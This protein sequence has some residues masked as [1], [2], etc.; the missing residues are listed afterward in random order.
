MADQKVNIKVSTTGA[1]KSK[2]ELSGLNGAI[3]KMGKAVGVASAAYF[4]AKGL[5]SAFSTVIEASARQEQ[6][7][8]ALEVALG[9]TSTALLNQASALQSVT[10]AGD[11]ALIEQQAFLASLKFTE[12]QIKTIIPVALDLSAATGISLESAVR[13]TSKTFSGLA[14]E[15]GELVPQLRELTQEE[16]KAGKAVEVLGKLFEGQASKQAET[17]AGALI[18]ASNSAGDLSEAIG[19]KL[20]PLVTKLALGFTDTT[21]SLTELLN[22]TGQTKS[23]TLIYYE[24]VERAEE[25]LKNYSDS[26]GITTDESLS[27]SD[28]ILQLRE[29]AEK[30]NDSEFFKGVAFSEAAKGL[31]DTRGLVEELDV[32]LQNFRTTALPDDRPINIIDPHEPELLDDVIVDMGEMNDI[33]NES[34]GIN[35]AI[36]K[37]KQDLIIQD[38]KNAALQQSSAK[39]AMKAVIRAETMEAVAGYIASVLKSVPF[40]A[41]LVLA[42]GGGALASGLIDKGLSSFAT[43]G[44]FVTSGPQMIMVGD[45][46]GGRERVQVSPLS[47]PNINGP[48]GGGVTV[49]ISAPLVDD[50][51]VESIIPAIQT[52]LNEDRATLKI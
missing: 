19:A 32:A 9:R 18:Q 46:P 12:D 30:V 3:T 43:G 45:N 23:E 22:I 17:M 29:E 1:K 21:S 25:V 33:M 41:N 51:V 11:E 31:R 37:Q 52:A 44:D 28:Q 39:D 16:M 5:I 13:N 20:S 4:G 42:A 2:D 36:K 6:A 49:N 27:L 38:L 24:T 7:E 50:T 10:T 34:F 8:K 14:G 48:G 40:P 35:K 26:L 47:S 15:L